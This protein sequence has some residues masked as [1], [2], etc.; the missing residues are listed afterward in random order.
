VKKV[1]PRTKT[2]NHIREAV[3]RVTYTN[4]SPTMKAE[5]IGYDEEKAWFIVKE[6]SEHTKYNE[7]AGQSFY[8]PTYMAICFNYQEE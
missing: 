6:H 7:C 1:T 4:I 2:I 3:G 5:L 8:V